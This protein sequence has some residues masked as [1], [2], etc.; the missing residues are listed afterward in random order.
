[1][2]RNSWSRRPTSFTLQVLA[3]GDKLVKESTAFALQQVITRS[4][5][6]TGAYR[7][8][9]KIS[10]GKPDNSYDLN[11]KDTSGAGAYAKG[12]VEI[13]KAKLGTIVYVQNCLPYSIS[14]ENGH[15][16]QAPSGVYSLAFQALANKFK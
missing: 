15:S 14:L 9:H 8:N 3:E 10:I 4:P 16:K 11:S 1:M 6:D 5:V 2:A 13:S 12:A 7:G